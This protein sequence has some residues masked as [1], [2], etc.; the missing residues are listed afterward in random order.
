[1]TFAIVFNIFSWILQLHDQNKPFAEIRSSLHV[2]E[3]IASSVKCKEPVL[4]VGETGTGKTTL[5]QY[6]AMKLGQKLTVLVYLLSPLSLDE[7][8]YAWNLLQGIL[9]VSIWFL[10]Q[11]LSQQS[12]VADLLGGFKPMDAQFIC[13]PLYKEFEDLFSKTFSMKVFFI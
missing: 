5:V 12:D 3:R 13:F 10:L 9:T 8:L 1:L 6:L 11:N 2:L 7:L 4:L